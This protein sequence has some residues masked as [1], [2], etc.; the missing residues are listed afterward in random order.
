MVFLPAFILL[1]YLTPVKYRNIT[2][3][4]GSIL[5]Y[6]YGEPLYVFLLLGSI[7][8]NY[9]VGRFLTIDKQTKPLLRKVLFWG[10]TAVDVLLLLAFKWLPGADFMPVV[11]GMPLGLSFYTF[12]LLSYL[13]DVY[14]GEIEAEK[15]LLKFGTYISMFPRLVAGPIVN[16]SE[17][18][19]DL[20][21]RTYRLSFVDEG[22]KRFVCGLALKVLLADSLGILWHEIATIGYESISTPLAWLGAFTYSMQI[23]F[24]FWGYSLMAVGLGRMLGF[25]LPE[26]F[27]MPYM[28]RSVREFYRRWHMT[29]GRW[30]Q[31]YVYIPLGGSKKGMFRN[32]GNLLFV[33]ILTALWHGG[34]LNFLLWGLSLF[35][36][37]VLERLFFG[38]RRLSQGGILSHLYVLIV[39][40]LTWMCFAIEDVG[41]LFIYFGRL[42]GFVEGINVNEMDIIR[43][44]SDYGWFLAVGVLC[45]TPL[46][47][48]FFSYLKDNFLGRF[49]LAVLF[50]MCVDRILTMG[51]NPFLYLRF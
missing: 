46:L 35:C 16:Y 26:N 22:L 36:L 2:L 44:L 23:Y 13:T 40:P 29:L 30:F 8:A 19:A 39:I 49:A 25:T 12:Q 4:V 34:S 21:Q 28:A 3:F 43:A 24:D 38:K 42:F 17:V 32:I 14:R 11:L 51:N 6:A 27:D 15:S 18:E 10:M 47:S 48:K 1:Y 50:W 41:D 9:T 7:A 33:W 5:F 37:I 20:K 31:K 45:C